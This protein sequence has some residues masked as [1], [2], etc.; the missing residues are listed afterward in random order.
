M[1]AEKD[2][3]GLFSS[4]LFFFHPTN[5]SAGLATKEPSL[6]FFFPSV[7]TD[8]RERY[9]LGGRARGVVTPDMASRRQFRIPCVRDEYIVDERFVAFQEKKK[10]K[11]RNRV[12][13]F[14][15]F[16][17]CA[18][19]GPRWAASRNWLSTDTRPHI[20]NNPSTRGPSSGRRRRQ[21]NRD[22]RKTSL[23]S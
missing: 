23:V 14:L 19:W 11:K 3:T 8:R 17:R 1:I 7:K 12:L 10:K 15:P 20:S 21:S 5:T 16:V 9:D 6:F 13:R 22:E 4:R 2:K 18:A